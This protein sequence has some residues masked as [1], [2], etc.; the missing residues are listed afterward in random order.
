MSL[1]LSNVQQK[2]F[3][4][5]VKQAFQSRGW[6]LK[7]CF[8]ERAN[9]EGT[10]VQFR[11]MGE[12]IAQQYA[13]QSQVNYQDPDF[14]PVECT[15]A[16]WRVATLL[17]DVER[18][19]VNFDER[20]EDAEAIAM[21][22]GRRADQMGIN[23]LDASG[24]TNIIVDGGLGMTFRKVR[25][26]AKF[27]D[28]NAVPPE[29]RYFA[30]SA[31]AQEDLFADDQ[32]TSN[33]YT[34]LNSITSGSLNNVYTM[35]MKWKVIPTMAEGGLPKTGNIRRCFAWQ[36]TAMGI[37]FGKYFTTQIERVPQYDSWQIL[38]KIFGNAVAVDAVG[39][40][41]VDIDESVIIP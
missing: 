28:D 3:D 34:N 23:A 36:K 6:L 41:R 24:T 37:A 29:E 35:G 31:K 30:I 17:D 33:F 12:L 9:V 40:V 18:F 10:Q 1:S 19:L 21:A 8:R 5:M 4:A 39:I 27:F 16:P 38:G 32:F 22:I 2:I 7:G 15:L 26:V 14:Q 25:E 13:F 11:K 20:K